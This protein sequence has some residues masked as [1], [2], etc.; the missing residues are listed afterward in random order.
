MRQ[1]LSGSFSKR[2]PLT[3]A[4]FIRSASGRG[5]IMPY[6]SQSGKQSGFPADGM[7]LP[8]VMTLSK[9][10]DVRTIHRSLCVGECA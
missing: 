9:R 7:R 4:G 3:G 1:Q 8:E 5:A 10:A 2:P 6:R